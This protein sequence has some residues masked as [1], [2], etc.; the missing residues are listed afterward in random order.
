MLSMTKWL[1]LCAVS[2]VAVLSGC[3]SFEMT[4]A[5]PPQA[6][7]VSITFSS[8]S[9]SGW[10]DLPIGT[11]QVP[12]S[13]TII[14]GHQK[15][16]AA[17]VLFGPLGLLVQGAINSGVG[18][19][20]TQDVQA[21]LRFNLTDEATELART[22]VST[23]KYGNTF[24]VEASEDSSI[25][26]VISAVVLTFDDD[27]KV[28]PFVVLKA[29]LTPPR[30]TQSQWSTRYMASSGI[31][32]PLTGEGSWTEHDAAALKR[33]VSEN[34]HSAIAFMLTDV[35]EPRQRDEAS[36]VMVQGNVP[37][38]RQRIQLV[39]YKLDEDD[40]SLVFVPKLGD[41]LV[42][43]GVNIMDK[44][45]TTQRPAKDD[46]LRFSIVDEKKDEGTGK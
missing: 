12:E 11:Y 30:S 34:L 32:R 10:S 9:L 31:A 43:A 37:Y 46:D 19:S 26:T 5:P 38:M 2:M 25:L 23:G 6:Q 20:K 45:S 39:G 16:G 36:M 15:G 3:A 18:S 14:S 17:G 4:K 24:A 22:L 7:P 33:T 27:E 21:L 1:R 41:V 29:S 13:Q 40:T 28:R 42:F 8:E 44:A 35:A